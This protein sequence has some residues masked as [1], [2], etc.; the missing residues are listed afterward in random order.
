MKSLKSYLIVAAAFGLLSLTM[1]VIDVAHLF[2]QGMKP[3]TLVRDVDAAAVRPFQA[4][5]CLENGSA[6]CSSLPGSLAVPFAT[7]SGEPVRRLVI[8][9]V[10]GEC[11]LVGS[12]GGVSIFGLVTAANG[13]S[14]L[15]RLVPVAPVVGSRTV[16]AQDTRI[17]ADPGSE[18]RF[19]TSV[20]GANSLCSMAVSGHL[21][22]E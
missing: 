1:S 14:L 5:L 21:V 10:S 20:I 16:A 19:V 4:E 12:S 6:T 7:S 11:L 3:A 9:Y 13:V 8:E 17:Y 2:A 22:V 15:H 18:V